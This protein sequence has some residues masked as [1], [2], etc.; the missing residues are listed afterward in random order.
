[1]AGVIFYNATSKYIYI[2]IELLTHL[3]RYSEA[4]EIGKYITSIMYDSPECW[5]AIAKLYL[6]KKQYENCLRVLNNVYYIEN[7]N[8]TKT[9]IRE[10]VQFVETNIFCKNKTNQISLKYLDLLVFSN[11]F[12]DFYVS[13]K[14]NF[15]YENT[16][17]LFETIDKITNNNYYN[18]DKNQRKIYY[19]LLEIIKEINFDAFINIKNKTFFVNLDEENNEENST[20]NKNNKVRI[21]DS[22]G[23][24]INNLIEDLKIFSIVIAQD[25]IYFNSL[26]TK[27]YLSI[28]ET[29]FCIA[30]G[31][32]SERLK[33]YNTS[34]KFYNKAQNFCFSKFICERKLVVLEKLR[35]FKNL[36]IAINDLLTC[37]PS[38]QFKQINRTPSWLD[39]IVLKVLFEHSINEIVAWISKD[40]NKFI[41]DFLVKKVINKYK[42]WIDAGHDLHLIK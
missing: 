31:I 6:H 29:K 42:Y 36:M 33:Y 26:L 41:I 2:E 20:F 21:R 18:Y 9:I 22:L 32:L 30:M 15:S 27:D 39:R 37:V 38:E 16:D 7:N 23:N 14:Q 28:I 35:D 40:T 1:M 25:E 3:K 24:I 11:K 17:V 12:V 8:E 13:N 4:L 10:G 34:L 5:I 19:I